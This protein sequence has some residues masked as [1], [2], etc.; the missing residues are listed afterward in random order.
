MILFALTRLKTVFWTLFY[1]S[2]GRS[3]FAQMGSRCYFEGWIDMPRHGGRIMLGDGVRI[4]PL[5]ELSVLEGAELFIGD[6]SFVGRGVL[7]NVARAVTVGK[8]VLIA[9]YCAIHDNDHVFAAP[10]S[11]IADQGWTA[12]P[13]SVGDDVWIGGH[14]MLVSGARVPDGCVI[15]AM[16]LVTR[17]TQIEPYAIVVGSPGR[18]IGSRQQ[19]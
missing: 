2:V 12:R 11:A 7:I 9:E 17:S 1:R 6:D 16:S 14:S 15:G 19:S 5:T 10:E 13:V 3:G 18:P 4:G 8:G